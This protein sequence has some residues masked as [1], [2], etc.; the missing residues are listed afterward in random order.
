MRSLTSEGDEEIQNALLAIHSRL[1]TIE[2][3][4]NLVARSEREQVLTVI[5]EAIQRA[6]LL[7]QIYLLLDGARTQSDIVAVLN[8]KG[9]STST[10]TVSR[11]MADLVTEYGLADEVSRSNGLV[12]RKNKGAD[13]VLNLTRKMRKWLDELGA[14]NPEPPTR[15]RRRKPTS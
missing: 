12:L 4:L 11:R 14:T 1:G 10:A 7:A 9:V 13:D 8:D 5:Q 15:R 2:G 3:K 6:P